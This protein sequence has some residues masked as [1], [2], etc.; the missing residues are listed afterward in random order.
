[1]C[2]TYF[3]TRKMAYTRIFD[4]VSNK[5]ARFL[6]LNGLYKPRNHQ[7]RLLKLSYSQLSKTHFEAIYCT[8]FTFSNMLAIF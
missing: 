3:D 6:S 8:I 2:C 4:I 7:P 1:M 5:I